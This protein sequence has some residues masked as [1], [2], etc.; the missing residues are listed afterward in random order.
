MK[1][2]FSIFLLAFGFYSLSVQAQRKWPL[3]KEGATIPLYRKINTMNAK[4]GIGID[5][6]RAD[7]AKLVKV[8]PFSALPK[9]WLELYPIQFGA[10][11]NLQVL[12]LATT[13]RWVLTDRARLF[14]SAAFSVAQENTRSGNTRSHILEAGGQYVFARLGHQSKIITG[15]F[16]KGERVT[17]S[18][19]T[20]NNLRVKQMLMVG[21]RTR[22]GREFL[23]L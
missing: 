1:H 20:S 16:K 15:I 14:G 19:V 8:N 7:Y 9:Y 23:V 10:N 18:S 3:A 21:V 2:F 13:G 22:I 6:F 4:G 5:T 17:S 11:D 12:R